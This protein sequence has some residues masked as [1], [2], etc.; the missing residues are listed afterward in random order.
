VVYL[1]VTI[2]ALSPGIYHLLDKSPTNQLAVSQVTD[3][4]T[5]GRDNLW[6]GQFADCEFVIITLLLFSKLCFKHFL[7]LTS[8]Q[9]D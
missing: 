7:E 6:Y 5:R 2:V 1:R 4:L 8:L 9:I 3:W